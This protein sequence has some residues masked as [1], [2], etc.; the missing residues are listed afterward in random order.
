MLYWCEVC[1]LKEV[2]NMK[3]PYTIIA[4]CLIGI[5]FF[6]KAGVA[7]A[8][9]LFLLVGAI[10]GTAYNVPAAGMLFI[11]LVPVWFVLVRITMLGSFQIWIK[12]QINRSN[13]TQK[14]RLSRKRL[15]QI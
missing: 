10:P 2:R 12:N 15:E 1:L 13:T 4:L 8:L 5:A 11:V 9:L 6:L 14:K 7:N 3:N